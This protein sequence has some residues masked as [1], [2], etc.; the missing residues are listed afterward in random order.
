MVF[1]NE[2]SIYACSGDQAQRAKGS[3]LNK[4]SQ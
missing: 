4:T 3:H 2:K 1:S